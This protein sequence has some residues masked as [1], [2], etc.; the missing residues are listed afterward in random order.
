MSVSDLKGITFMKSKIKGKKY[1]AL[2]K[3]GSK[4]HFGSSDHEHFKDTVPKS[5]GGGVW[6]HKN[7]ND[8]GRRRS[9]RNRHGKIKT[10]SGKLAYRVK[11]SPAW[12]SYNFLW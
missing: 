4:V 12:F 11:F 1:T 9:Y 3:D 8:K 10:K 5:L 7:H 2:L 6:S